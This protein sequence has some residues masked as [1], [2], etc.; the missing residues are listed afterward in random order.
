MSI[1]KYWSTI[2]AGALIVSAMNPGGA[3]AVSVGIT[4]AESHRTFVPIRYLSERFGYE[5]SW[6]P[7]EQRV[8]VLRG[9]DILTLTIG[10]LGVRWKDAAVLNDAAPYVEHGVTYVPLRVI[11][12]TFGMTVVWD[13]AAQGVLVSQ[14]G[15]ALL[16]PVV[17]EARW[18]ETAKS[19]VQHTKQTYLVDERRMTANVVTVDLLHP[20]VRLDVG[21]ADGTIGAV[22]ALQDIAEAGG[23]VAAI[24]G[25]FFN[26][27]TD[28]EVKSPY[29]YIAAGGEVVNRAP[30]DR[31]TVLLFDTANG[32]EMVAGDTFLDRF[33][34]RDV[35]GSLQAGPRLLT[36][37]KIT[38][39]PAEEGFKDPKILTNAGAR[40]AVGLTADHRLILLTTGGATIPQLA[41]MMLQA[42]AKEA[43]NLDGGAS[44]GLYLQ[45]KYITRPGREISNALLVVVE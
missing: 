12:E 20:K 25:T 21:V 37:G 34:E 31:R 45:G 40:S 24:N 28:S 38:V 7:A 22:S 17:P 42:G 27:Y 11:A 13:A 14:E 39:N 2:L 8:Q 41:E 10:E 4:D 44:S 32:V 26:A 23:A 35:S 36:N 5:V 9:D 6:D 15:A 3:E 43:M 19:P 1:R 18:K 29:G 33:A 16:V 30:G